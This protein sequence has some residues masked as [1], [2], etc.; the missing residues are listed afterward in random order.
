MPLPSCNH[1]KNAW[2]PCFVHM[3]ESQNHFEYH[4]RKPCASTT[5]GRNEKDKQAAKA[6]NDGSALL[7]FAFPILES[8][9]PFSCHYKTGYRCPLAPQGF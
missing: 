1:D 3:N 6:S 9:T 2:E 7:G 4:C 8:L 5:I